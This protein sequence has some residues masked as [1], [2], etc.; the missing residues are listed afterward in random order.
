MPFTDKVEG[1]DTHTR[2]LVA[3]TVM[4]GSG[5][6]IMIC[7]AFDWQPV[8]VLVPVTWYNVEVVG[9]TTTEVEVPRPGGLVHE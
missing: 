9:V 8:I 6:T 4:V 1:P 2:V 3:E 7:W 5:F